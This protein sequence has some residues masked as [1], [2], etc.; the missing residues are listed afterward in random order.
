[1]ESEIPIKNI[2]ETTCVFSGANS[3][4]VSYGNPFARSLGGESLK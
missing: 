1:M 3:K 2:E 4:M